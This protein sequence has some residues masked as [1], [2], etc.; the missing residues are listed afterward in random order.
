[1]EFWKGHDTFKQFEHLTFLTWTFVVYVVDAVT[2]CCCFELLL[3]TAR[4]LIGEPP[5]K[6]KLKSAFGN[7]NSSLILTVISFIFVEIY[8]SEVTFPVLGK[9]DVIHLEIAHEKLFICHV[10]DCSDMWWIASK[11]SLTADILIWRVTKAKCLVCRAPEI[12][13]QK[14]II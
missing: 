6:H 14:C 10:S 8:A 4:H 1:M 13:R 5:L 2:T 3:L 9:K 7:K 11:K 12:T